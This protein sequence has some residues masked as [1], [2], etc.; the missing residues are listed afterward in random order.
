M[1]A[2]RKAK[3]TTKSSPKKTANAIKESAGKANESM[4]DSGKTSYKRGG[5]GKLKGIKSTKIYYI[6]AI[7]MII[8]GAL[9][10]ARGF[11]V[12]AM[13]N[14]H[15]ITRYA[16]VKQ[17][18]KQGGSQ[19]LDSM[20]TE[21]LVNQEIKNKGITISDKD[22]QDEIDRISG[23]V[24]SQGTTLDDALAAQGQTMDDLRKNVKLRLSAEKILQDSISVTDQEAKDYFDQNKSYYADDAKY[25]DMSADIK[26]QLKQ[27]KLQ[28]EFQKLIDQLKSDANI[29]YFVNYQSSN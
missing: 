16:V 24:E 21:D 14:G 6:V 10:L 3:K 22:I 9:Y 20:I 1:A 7:V 11:F 4:L 13:V 8:V 5:F 15:P 18:E 26:D 23:V 12:V 19:V 27:Q 29:T 28:T 17:L 25:E 2:K